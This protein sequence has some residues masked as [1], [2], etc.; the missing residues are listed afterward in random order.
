[1]RT[2]LIVVTLFSSVLTLA[3]VC[4]LQAEQ[5]PKHQEAVTAQPL[6]AQ[7]KRLETALDTIGEPLS[8]SIKSG[9]KALQPEQGDAAVTDAVMKLLDPLCLL[10]VSINKDG[11]IAASTLMD[12]PELVEQGWKTFLV[13]VVNTGQNTGELKYDSPNAKPVPKGEQSKVAERWLDIAPMQSN[14]LLVKLSGLELEY[15][16]LQLY[17]R[18]KGDRQGKLIVKLGSKEAE[19]PLSVHAKASTPVSFQV[20]DEKGEPCM[21]CFEI[22]DDAAE[23]TRRW[24]SGSLLTSSSIRKSIG[25]VANRYRYHRAS[26]PSNAL[27]GRSRYR[28]NRSWW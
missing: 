22:R 4:W 28:K 8:E 21:G 11:S 14:P 12:K 16:V 24:P 20:R 6:L 7:V 17:C 27:V 2:K 13:K 10:S 9:L 3:A 19:L 26:T 1:M 5:P 23:S 25:R 15:R 18:D